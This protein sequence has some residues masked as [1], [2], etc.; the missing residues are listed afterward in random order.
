MPH[1]IGQIDASYIY[2]F[3][4]LTDENAYKN[5]YTCYFVISCSNYFNSIT[6]IF[7][8][9]LVQFFNVRFKEVYDSCC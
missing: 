1:E 9:I 4:L 5:K 8:G 7:N 2:L 6:N 3:K